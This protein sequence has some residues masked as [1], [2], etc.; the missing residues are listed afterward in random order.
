MKPNSNHS[1]ITD[2]DGHV[3]DFSKAPC[4]TKLVNTR[5]YQF[6]L[7]FVKDHMIGSELTD[8]NHIQLQSAGTASC[9]AYLVK[10]GFVAPT[11][12]GLLHIHTRLSL[13]FL[14]RTASRMSIPPAY[15]AIHD[16]VSVLG[17]VLS[18]GGDKSR[19]FIYTQLLKSG[20]QNSFVDSQVEGLLEGVEECHRDFFNDLH[21]YARS[22]LILFGEELGLTH[23]QVDEIIEANHKALRDQELAE[24]R[25][26]YV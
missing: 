18:W 8:Q 1:S 20:W 6:I 7:E 24:E 22:D 9:I 10:I 3:I 14:E 15:R 17:F 5:T 16:F 25:F 4:K 12:M 13:S 23:G 19:I 11:F 26:V 2:S 21:E